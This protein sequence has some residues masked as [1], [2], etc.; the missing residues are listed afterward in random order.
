MKKLE[1][2]RG[3]I[4]RIPKRKLFFVEEVRIKSSL[5]NID[6]AL[7]HLIKTGEIQRITRG[8]YIRPKKSSYPK[9]FLLTAS[10]N[11]IIKAISK[12]TGEII[13]SYWAEAVNYVGLSTQIQLNPIYFTTGRSRYIKIN[14]KFDI[15][16]VHINPKKLVMPGT[17]TCLVITALWFTRSSVNPISIKKIHKRI[18]DENFSE[19]LRHKDKMPRWMVKIFDKY[20]SMEQD[21]PELEEDL[22]SYY[23]G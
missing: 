3:V 11:E 10:A 8:M 13:S 18:D 7:S 21:C 16:L 17:V 19:V 6:L 5:K 4:K 15:K 23:Q 12:K 9:G 2:V 22:S 1:I 20:L 14:K